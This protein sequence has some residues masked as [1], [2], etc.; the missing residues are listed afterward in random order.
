MIVLTQSPPEL[1]RRKTSNP[2][3]LHRPLA[4][5]VHTE[6]RGIAAVELAL[7]FP[8]LL[9]MLL[10]IVDFGRYYNATITATHA[11]REAARTLALGGTSG[12]AASSA[13]TAASPMT[14][15]VGAVT[16][17]PANGIGNASVTVST[18]FAFDPLLLVPGLPSSIS[19]T[20]VMRCGG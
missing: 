7:I 11:A 19:R 9:M 20:A 15:T 3:S 18:A 2:Q 12:N 17:C 8:V 5:L 10:A 6:E 4:P 1:S 13:T 14:V 16:T